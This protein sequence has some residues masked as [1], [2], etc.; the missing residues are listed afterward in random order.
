[1]LRHGW[2]G[3]AQVAAIAVVAV[4]AVYRERATLREGFYA[5]RYIRVGWLPAGIGA[6]TIS[7]VA[8][9]QLER[10]LLRGVH[11]VRGVDRLPLPDE[12]AS[13]TKPALEMPGPILN[14]TLVFLKNSPEPG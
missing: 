5:L 2:V 13:A 8:L 1:M 3:I 14:K 7:M 12:A 11:L 4:V 10:G 6:E 9:A